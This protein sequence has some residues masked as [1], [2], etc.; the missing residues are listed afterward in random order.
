MN[1]QNTQYLACDIVYCARSFHAAPL[2][3]PAPFSHRSDVFVCE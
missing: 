3:P 1:T 2:V